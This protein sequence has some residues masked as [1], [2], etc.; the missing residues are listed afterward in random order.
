MFGWRRLVELLMLYR[1]IR[2]RRCAFALRGAFDILVVDSEAHRLVCALISWPL[3]SQI[4]DSA[5][6]DPIITLE[7]AIILKVR[8]RSIRIM[9]SKPWVSWNTLANCINANLVVSARVGM[10]TAVPS[11]CGGLVPLEL[12][13]VWLPEIC[14]C[15]CRCCMLVQNLAPVVCEV[16]D[17]ETWACRWSLHT[18]QGGITKAAS[19]LVSP[20]N[21]PRNDATLALEDEIPS[22]KCLWYL[23]QSAVRP[24]PV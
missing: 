11:S 15:Y 9:D 22:G 12:N 4:S 10:G 13:W 7:N 5:V 17:D 14:L 8:T 2:P 1:S 18:R 20:M 6:D 19:L 3:A 24:L 21:P 16:R 23:L